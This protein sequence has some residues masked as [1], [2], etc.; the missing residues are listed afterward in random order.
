MKL[1]SGVLPAVRS[2]KDFDKAL[3]SKHGMIVLLETRLSQLKS[4][5]AYAHRA[6]KKVII[7]FDLIQG[8]K[9]DEYGMEYILRE[10]K[11]DGIISTRGNVIGLA[12]KQHILAIQRV[13][14]LDSLAIEHNQ[15]LI[16]RIK[17]D[18]I[19]VL[20]G[21]IPEFIEN[22]S[23]KTKTPVIA[24][25]L[26]TDSKEVEDALAAGAVAVSTSKTDLW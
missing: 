7:H 25:G 4:L 13:F 6:D 26:I 11:P 19:E 15:T 21:L 16:E 17:P 1:P 24:G 18:C 3:E 14:L 20:P 2:M 22:F 5:V 12:K 23:K 8:L 10:I 9:T